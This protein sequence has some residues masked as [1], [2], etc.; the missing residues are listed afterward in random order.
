MPSFIIYFGAD[1]SLPSIWTSLW[2]SMTSLLQAI[3][4][5]AGGPLC[6]RI[7]R[8][9]PGVIAGL[10]SLVGTAVLYT[11]KG[12][13]VLLVGKMICGLAI[14]ISMAVG[15]TYASEVGLLMHS[16]IAHLLIHLPGCTFQATEFRP[17]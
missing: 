4:A 11:A 3:G 2:V 1:G 6:D 13:V 17:S 8:K 9:W 12:R 10:I 16:R 7:G 14:G 15:M 5:V